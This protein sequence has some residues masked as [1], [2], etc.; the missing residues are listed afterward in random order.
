M[1]FFSLQ[2]QK[3]ISDLLLMV[4]HAR[5]EQHSIK[6]QTSKPKYQDLATLL[7]ENFDNPEQKKTSLQQTETF[8]LVAAK[9]L[10]P[11]LRIW[12]DSSYAGKDPKDNL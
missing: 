6:H 10:Y 9:L 11:T 1:A 8:K 2:L 7:L 4:I 3:L 12:T 5:R